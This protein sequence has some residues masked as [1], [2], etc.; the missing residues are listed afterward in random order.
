LT[1]FDL[2]QA[3]AGPLPV[4]SPD[5][6]PDGK[7]PEAAP[8]EPLRRV[9][10]LVAYDGT[11]FHGFAR[12]P[13]TRTVGGELAASLEQMS[14]SPV[15]IVCAGRTDTGVHALAQVVHVD[16]PSAWLEAHTARRKVVG[17]DLTWLA[18]SVSAQLGSEVAVT[19]AWLAAEGFDAR[20]SALA[21]RY[22]YDILNSGAP[23]P[24]LA[25]STWFVPR[26]LDLKAMRTASDTLT[27]EHDFAAFCR[28]P[29]DKPQGPICRRVIES[30]WTVLA[31]PADVLRFEIE[32][33][34][35]C[36]QMVRSLVG[37]LVAVGEGKMT[38]ADVYALLRSGD[39]A[40]AA[41]PAPPHGL[42]LVAV[43]YCL[44][45]PSETGLEVLRASN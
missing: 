33:T 14:G 43:R 7:D 42:C 38:P 2:P 35:F 23:K 41:R 8:R 6:D 24:L 37:S 39:R 32:A 27:G 34:A 15:E 5:S 1:L 31:E 18:H 20:H 45:N 40:G 25:R 11:D 10:M 30:G 3:D 12:Q 26:A 22:R 16:L 36:H 17:G 44:P 19:K 21:R 9:A 28:R 4:S 29:P 13:G